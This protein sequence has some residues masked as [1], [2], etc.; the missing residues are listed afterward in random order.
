MNGGGF[1]QN[2]YSCVKF[3]IYIKKKEI[4]KGKKDK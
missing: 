2:T 4:D 1:G 3:S